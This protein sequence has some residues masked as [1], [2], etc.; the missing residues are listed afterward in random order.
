[1]SSAERAACGRIVASER[2]WV[3]MTTYQEHGTR[4]FPFDP[5]TVTGVRIDG[6][7]GVT[8]VDS[9]SAEVVEAAGE[10]WLHWQ[11]NG[12]HHA[13]NTR[14][15]A[16]LLSKSQPE[17]VIDL[18]EVEGPLAHILKPWHVGASS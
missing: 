16:E 1:L 17:T 3:D 12:V 10:T 11:L 14:H 18:T 9:G 7:P 8:A 13:V 15:I 4:Q 2:W 5:A 6:S